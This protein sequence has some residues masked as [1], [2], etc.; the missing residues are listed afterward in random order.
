MGLLSSIFGRK[1]PAVAPE[2][3]LFA[4]ATAQVDLEMRHG[5]VPSGKAGVCFR[6]MSSSFFG[7][8]ERELQG[9]LAAGERTA[10]T[11][12]KV[13]DDDYGFRWVILADDDFE[14]LV[15]AAYIV[16]QAFGEH[17]YRDQ[18]LAAV[19]PFR[20]DGRD[21]QWIYGYRRGRF[22]PFVPIPGAQRRDNPLELSLSAKAAGSLPM[23]DQV[24]RWYA[25]WGA[26]FHVL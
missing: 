23:E 3:G 8:L 26:P 25:L 18:L 19:F 22:Y 13:V 9:L 17:G 7:E 16:T 21:V 14:D 20:Q 11:R 6:V 12:H 10:G 4:L 1:K 2:D 24:E 15:T 5:L